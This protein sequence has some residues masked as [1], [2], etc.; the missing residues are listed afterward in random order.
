[1]RKN[2]TSSNEKYNRAWDLLRAN[3]LQEA[4]VLFNE[5]CV[6]DQQNEGLW[7]IL[8]GLNGSLGDAITAETC[9][10]KAVALSPEN[11]DAHFN[12]G[13]ALREQKKFAQSVA[14][15]ET[16]IK[17]DPNSARN[18]NA[19]GCV[20]LMQGHISS[21][22]EKLRQAINIDPRFADAHNNLG[23]IFRTT[24]RNDEAIA[25]YRTAVEIQPDHVNYMLNLSTLLSDRGK[26]EEAIEW[27]QRILA[28]RPEFAEAHHHLGNLFLGVDRLEE[29]IECF[30]RARSIKPDFVEA[31]GA[32]AK[33]LQKLGRYEQS[34]EFIRTAL[35]SGRQSATLIAAL[36]AV[37]G[38]LGR[39]EETARL[40][41][42]MLRQGGLAAKDKQELHF[43]A[44]KLYDEMESY[45]QAFEHYRQANALYRG[46]FSRETHS[47]VIDGS[48]AFFQPERIQKL[49]TAER[50][51][52]RPVFI[53]GMPRSGTSLVEQ[54]LA[55]HP[56]FHGMGEL[57]NINNYAN[58]MSAR[59]GSPAPYPDCL[60]Q[61][62]QA[63]IDDLAGQYLDHLLELDRT[64]VRVTDKMPH[65]FLHLGM[66]SILFPGARVIHTRRDPMDTCL[67]IYQQKFNERHAY[68]HDL[69]DQG[70]YYRSYEKLM[71]HWHKVLD[72]PVLDVQYEDLVTDPDDWIPRLVEFCEVEWD[73]RCMQF[74]ESPRPVNTPSSEQARQP[75]Y[76]SSAGRWHRYE[77]HLKALK[78]A[79]DS[80]SDV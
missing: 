8:A 10:R 14:S 68:A 58:E 45:Q 16:A 22:E 80:W 35:E 42:E 78:I 33:T 4:R 64:A 53:V 34:C 61:A 17:F 5:L 79:L 36:A 31:Y 40:A 25:S 11:A 38:H 60:G 32:E 70:F 41:E 20:L 27:D 43:V 15:F 19:L 74:H 2:Q 13:I 39:R 75:I 28:L 3:Q 29:A 24:H 67:S 76:S 66:I 73:D 56:L 49:P 63:I 26:I 12:L 55:S 9:A 54:I 65:N 18:F 57:N 59:I 47:R 21:A 7:L 30:R 23:N 48:I 37:S 51:S 44:G 1:M 77:P 71:E 72:L 46:R 6:L 52:D 50:V 62:T 69:S